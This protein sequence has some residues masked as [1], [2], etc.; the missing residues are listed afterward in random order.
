MHHNQQ[1]ELTDL[2][3]EAGA[4]LKAAGI[5]QSDAARALGKS[6]S[7]VSRALTDGEGKMVDTL[8]QIIARYTDFEIEDQP[9]TL[10]R[11]KRKGG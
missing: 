10:Y 4:A 5:T 2:R 8:R 9:T 11:V 6:R 7:T 1:I 3:D